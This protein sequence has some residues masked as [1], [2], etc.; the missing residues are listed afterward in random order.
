MI[1]PTPI[2]GETEEEVVKQISVMADILSRE[3]MLS[4]LMKDYRILSSLNHQFTVPGFDQTLYVHYLMEE[5]A[6]DT[7]ATFHVCMFSPN[8]DYITVVKKHLALFIKR[9]GQANLKA[10]A[11]YEEFMVAKVLTL[12][13]DMGGSKTVFNHN[14]KLPCWNCIPGTGKSFRNRFFEIRRSTLLSVKK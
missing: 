4:P 12:S 11:S 14:Q 1:T 5:S 3:I 6:P 2:M 8:V 13:R 10:P 9:I 7:D